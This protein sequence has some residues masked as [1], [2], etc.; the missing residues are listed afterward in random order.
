MELC[1]STKHGK[2]TEK[3]KQLAGLMSSAWKCIDEIDG[4]S[5]GDGSGKEW[6]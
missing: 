6:R 1:R 2:E 4:D 3:G 5:E